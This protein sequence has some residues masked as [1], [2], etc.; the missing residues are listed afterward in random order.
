MAEKTPF[1]QV[2]PFPFFFF[3]FGCLF[4]VKESKYF[5]SVNV[6]IAVLIKNHYRFASICKNRPS[7][8]F[9]FLCELQKQRQVDVRART[10]PRFEACVRNK[11]K[12]DKCGGW[13]EKEMLKSTLQRTSSFPRSL[14]LFAE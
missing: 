3:F 9:C 5:V 14:F 11:G 13:K 2:L 12:Q 6:T 8:C 7:C 10:R 1:I 4:V